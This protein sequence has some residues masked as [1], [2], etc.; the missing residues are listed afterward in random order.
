MKITRK[1]L[2]QIVK[3]EISQSESSDNPLVPR[4]Y[5]DFDDPEYGLDAE[6]K[7]QAIRSADQFLAKYPKLAPIGTIIK[8]LFRLGFTIVPPHSANVQ[9]DASDRATRDARGQALV[10]RMTTNERRLTRRQLR[11]T[12]AE[13]SAFHMSKFDQESKDLDEATDAVLAG[14]NITVSGQLDNAG[15]VKYEIRE[16]IKS[17]LS[18]NLSVVRMIVALIDEAR[19][20]PPYNDKN[21]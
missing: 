18:K 19:L 1:Q 5:P 6:V 13:A 21:G 7:F 9:A 20:A 14:I 16:D 8:G 17:V 3:E 10:D 2:A 4:V 11:Q 15:D 12:I